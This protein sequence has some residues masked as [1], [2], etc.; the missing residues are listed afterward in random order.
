[1]VRPINGNHRLAI[2]FTLSIATV[3]KAL[4]LTLAE[5]YYTI[6]AAYSIEMLTETKRA[7]PMV[8]WCVL[9]WFFGLE[10]KRL[11]MAARSNSNTNTLIVSF[12]IIVLL[13]CRAAHKLSIQE[14]E[15]MYVYIFA[16]YVDMAN[17]FCNK[18]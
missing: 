9:R 17:N 16:S 12:S 14:H 4:I 3:S 13:Y 18:H 15:C 7:K 11:C 2:N 8:D 10:K 5:I 1:M 6:E